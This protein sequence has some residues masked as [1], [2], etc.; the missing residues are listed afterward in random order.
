VKRDMD[1]VVT[2]IMPVGRD[3]ILLPEKYVDSPLIDNYVYPR[4]RVIQFDIG[5]ETTEEE[6]YEKLRQACRE[7]YEKN[8]IDIPAVNITVNLLLL[9]NTEEYK[10][11][12]Q[13]E[14]VELGD[15]VSCTDNPLKITFE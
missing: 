2:R 6:A 9:E 3:G 12:K 13:L 7:L 8:K 1:T 15:I 11:L 14:K 10:N 4:V 5:E